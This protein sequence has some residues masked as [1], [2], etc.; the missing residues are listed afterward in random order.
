[1]KKL[2]KEEVTYIKKTYLTERQRKGRH[3]KK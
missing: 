3:I 2:S 1:M